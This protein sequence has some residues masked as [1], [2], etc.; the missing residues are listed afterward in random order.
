M[1]G[2]NAISTGSRKS[3]FSHLSMVATVGKAVGLCAQRTAPV[4]FF[5]AHWAPNDLAFVTNSRFP[6][7][8]RQGAF[9]AFHGSWNRAPGP[10]GGFNVVFQPMKDGRASAPYVVFAD[11]FAGPGKRIGEGGISAHGSRH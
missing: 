11:G 9:V 3:W 7:A 5:P 10:Q 1:A 4:A 2:R 6:A 8:Y